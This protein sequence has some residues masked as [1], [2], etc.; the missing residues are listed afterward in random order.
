MIVLTRRV[1]ALLAALLAVI[2][3]QAHAAYPERPIR[4]IVPFP[5]GGSADQ[6]GRL[7]TSVVAK[8]LQQTIVIENKTGAG[9]AIGMELVAKAA[10]DGYTLVLASIGPMSILPVGVPGLSYDPLRD[11]ELITLLTTNPFLVVI[12]PSVPATTIAQLIAYLKS[13][14]GKLNYA[15]VGNGSL[16][17]LAGELF[18]SQ[19]G[20]DMVHIPF[21]GGAPAM[22]DTVAGH[23]Q[24]MFA[25]IN[26]ALPFVTAG[27]LRVLGVTSKQR[28]PAV[29]NVPTLHESG[30]AGYEAIAWN[31]IAAPAGTSR[32]IVERLRLEMGEA[33]RSPVVEK[34][35]RELGVTPVGSTSAAF[36]D[37]VRDEQAK[38]GGLIKKL[39][40]KLD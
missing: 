17:H 12:H 16:G 31:G 34:S 20:V 11:L 35:F 15:S 37:L 28:H 10:P 32:E 24:V 21:R 27:K 5:A 40:I 14:P 26:E 6:V 7:L 2:A 8:S 29:P 39:N 25:N 3:F 18:K 33:L 36:V 19:A 38:W 1:I 13:N 22:Q 4:V 30:L 23:T 9:G